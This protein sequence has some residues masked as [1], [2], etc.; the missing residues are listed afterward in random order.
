M[1]TFYEKPRVLKNDDL[2]EGVYMA[3]GTGSACYTAWGTKTQSPQEGR[4][5]YVFQLDGKHN[6]TTTDSHTNNA[7][8]VT[9]SFNQKVT[10][11]SSSGTLVSGDDTSKLVIS[12]AYWQN[13][14]DN[15]GLGN[16]SVVS[17]SGLLLT[18]ITISD[19][20]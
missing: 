17:E 2:S 19:G 5:T 7:Q 10:Y 16:L 14:T 15:I 9:V 4:G 20:H 11:G 8:K 6:S 13:A 12:Y 1:K 3:S 18:G